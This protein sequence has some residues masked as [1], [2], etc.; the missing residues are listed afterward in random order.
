M[1]VFSLSCS[2]ESNPAQVASGLSGAEITVM[3]GGEGEL[4]PSRLVITMTAEEETDLTDTIQVDNRAQIIRRFVNIAPYK[5]WDISAVTLDDNDSVIHHGENSFRSAPNKVH[6]IH[7]ELLSN[8]FRMRAFI[9]HAHE[10]MTRA[11]LTVDGQRSFETPVEPTGGIRD[12]VKVCADYIPLKNA[13]QVRARVYGMHEGSEIVMYDGEIEVTLP[14]YDD[15]LVIFSLNPQRPYYSEVPLSVLLIPGSGN[16]QAGRIGQPLL[17]NRTG[18]YYDVVT[19]DRNISW[20]EARSHAA[21]L[22]YNG[23]QGHLAT[24]TSSGENQFIYEYLAAQSGVSSLHIGAFQAPQT[25]ETA[26]NWQWITGEEWEF[27]NWSIGEPN[28]FKDVD[29]RHLMLWCYSGM[30]ND[31]AASLRGFVVEYEE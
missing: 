31:Q 13:Y 7:M 21:S 20:E 11:L 2:D 23:L 29:E 6:D 27:T 25:A 17:Y 4:L 30:W 18:H 28:D 26:E 10:G 22:S 1:L 5:K 16:T 14:W 15:R 19:F 12:T 24:I 8:F 3:L 9:A